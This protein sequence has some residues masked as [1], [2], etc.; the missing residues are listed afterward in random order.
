MEYKAEEAGILFLKVNPRNT[1]KGCSV[2]GYIYEDMDL[3]VREWICPIC[4]TVHERD[5]NAAAI[6]DKRLTQKIRQELPEYTL[7]ETG[8]VDD[9]VSSNTYALKSTPSMNQEASPVR[10]G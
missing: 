6:V 1:S 2:C 9:I 10:A 3:S 8:N 7:E 5:E 4:N